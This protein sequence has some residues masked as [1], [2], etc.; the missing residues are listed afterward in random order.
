[1]ENHARIVSAFGHD[2]EVPQGHY[3]LSHSVGCLPVAARARLEAGLF[4]PW[5]GAGSDGWPG[6]LEA[7]G[8]FTTALARLFG[9]DPAQWCPQQGVS[10]G[11]FRF[12]SALPEG[13]RRTL[14]VSEHAFP[15]IGYAMGGLDRFGY[16]LRIVAGDPADMDLWRAAMGDDVAAIVIMHVH[17]NSGIVSPVADLTALARARGIVSVVDVCQSAGIVPFSVD[18]WD[19]DAVV[20][21]CVKWLCG[22]PGAGFLWVRPDGL[23]RLAPPDRGWFSHENPFAFDIADF[24]Y[25]PDARRFWGG[26]PS[27]APYVLATA[28]IDTIE[29]IGIDRLRAHNRVLAQALCDA[30]P[31]WVRVDRARETGG[32]LCLDLG[33]SAAAAEAGLRAAGC[34]VD[35]RHQT[36]RISLH[37]YN[38][39]EDAM[40]VARALTRM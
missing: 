6:W 10:A 38:G 21:S 25:A 37:A 40:A 35:R 12:L 9:G 3:L 2:F 16:R 28:G 30:L 31:A 18:L 32:T 29:A 13:T 1:M 17:S 23:E 8:G 34:R 7:V 24:R 27:I 14:L 5:S 20:G 36:L 4:R 22:G 19:A 11:L 39:I 33:A 26:T 15:S